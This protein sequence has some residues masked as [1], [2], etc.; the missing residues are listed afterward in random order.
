M[1]EP[2]MY[3]G[4]VYKHNHLVELVEDLGGYILQ[5]NIMQTE[6]VIIMLVPMND[7]HLVENMTKK[8]L[9]VLTR[10]PLSGTE[11]AVVAP[12]LA[13]HHLPHPD[14]DIAEFLRR[15]G[16]KTNMIGLAR[17]VGARVCQISGH[18]RSLI[19]EHDVAVYILGNFKHCIV[20][21]KPKILE[22]IE[23]PVVVTG[24]PEIDVEEIPMADAYVGNLGRI[25]HRMRKG[26]EMWAMDEAVDVVGEILDKERNELSKDPLCVMPPRVKKEIED[27]I[28][29][30]ADVLSPL[31]VT[32]KLK[33]MRV[34]LDYDEFHKRIENISFVEGVKLKDIAYIKKGLL[35]DYILIE[36]KPKSETGFVI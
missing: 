21:N 9:G 27:Q 22:G 25:A 28:P 31:P 20:E 3:E 32:L 6:I 36:I 29:E 19:N 5:T 16:A 11:I 4:G 17:G 33:G 30:I 35:K 15:K 2:I 1:L 34:K 13:Y 18:E 23:I 24:A 10:A 12:T 14:C 8:L 26:P 7:I